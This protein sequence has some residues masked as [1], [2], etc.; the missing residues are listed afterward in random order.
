MA[1]AVPAA[2]APAAVIASTAA[3]TAAGVNGLHLEQKAYCVNVLLR[4][5]ARCR[6]TGIDGNH[7]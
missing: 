6:D 1:R 2:I 7:A 5:F 3:I 4:Q